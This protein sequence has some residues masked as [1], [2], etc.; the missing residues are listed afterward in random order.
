[1]SSRSES[2]SSPFIYLRTTTFRLKLP[3][4]NTI[5]K[6][7]QYSF[8]RY[9]TLIILLRKGEVLLPI[10]L[11]HYKNRFSMYFFWAYL[12][13]CE[14]PNQC[15]RRI[16]YGEL[17]TLRRSPRMMRLF[18]RSFSLLKDYRNYNN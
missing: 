2:V 10:D 7:L 14:R 12:C 18:L 13:R 3:L 5:S 1:M 16:R 6:R 17:N 9:I 11:C 4:S 8:K 15:C